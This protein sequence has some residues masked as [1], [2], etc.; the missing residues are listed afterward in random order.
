MATGPDLPPEIWDHIAAYCD[1]ASA[2]LLG[3]TCVVLRAIVKRRVILIWA[4]ARA[5]MDGAVDCWERKAAPWDLAWAEP[6]A[7]RCDACSDPERYTGTPYAVR[8][9]QWICDDGV[10]G[11]A[12]ARNV[13]DACVI[14]TTAAVTK[15]ERAVW[16]MRRVE[17]GRPH[18]WSAD[19]YG[20]VVDVLSSE[21][22][23]AERFVVPPPATHL[24]DPLA[25]STIKRWARQDH[26]EVLFRGGLAP[27]LLPSVRAWLPL[28]GAQHVVLCDDTTVR[29]D[30]MRLALVCCDVAS[31]MWG[32]VLLVD[33]T[34]SERT[35]VWAL[36]TDSLGDLLRRYR[37]R[38]APDVHMG[39]VAWLYRSVARV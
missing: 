33:H 12:R 27:A 19:R 5:A 8:L 35:A 11:D 9:R 17:L 15:A 23:P 4:T 16:P 38:P 34:M 30:V 22:I 26:V 7:A 37:D 18:V 29:H 1:R 31:A 6:A 32:A 13:C 25:P 3:G 14:R 10:P 2:A 21:L 20:E 24:I 28:A 36:A 39:L